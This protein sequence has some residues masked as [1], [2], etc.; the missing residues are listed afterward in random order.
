MKI[1]EIRLDNLKIG[2]VEKQSRIPAST[3]RYY[4]DI[5]IIPAPE[6]ISG[7]R[8]Y[9]QEIFKHLAFIRLA[10]D[11]GFQLK[12]IKMILSS[13]LPEIDRETWQSLA[14]QKLDEINA[15]I[16]RY[17]MMKELLHRGLACHCIDLDDCELLIGQSGIF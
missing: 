5:G 4:E 8:I 9:S 14:A 7:Q 15:L 16:A 6:R 12:E 17:T 1:R 11:T 10:Q 3:L 13:D 2:D